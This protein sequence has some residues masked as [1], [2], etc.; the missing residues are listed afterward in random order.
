MLRERRPFLSHVGGTSRMSLLLSTS[1]CSCRNCAN[2]AGGMR[3]T[4]FPEAL[5]TFRSRS[6]RTPSRPSPVSSL[7]AVVRYVTFEREHGEHQSKCRP[8]SHPAL[9][10]A[11]I[12]RYMLGRYHNAS[13]LHNSRDWGQSSTIYSVI[14]LVRLHGGIVGDGS[15]EQATSQAQ[16]ILPGVKKVRGRRDVFLRQNKERGPYIYRRHGFEV[17][18]RLS[19]N[20]IPG[21]VF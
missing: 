14:R 17:Q 11:I 16:A 10:P 12:P 8:V 7:P 18:A 19:G 2:T 13:L 4:R 9:R 6:G 5:K 21:I 3:F 20:V 1:A 15:Q